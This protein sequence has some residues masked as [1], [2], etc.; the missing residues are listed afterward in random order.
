YSCQCDEGFAGDLCEIML[1]HDFF[2]FGSF[3]VCENTLQGPLCHCERGRTG[4]NCELFKGESAPWSKCGNSTF[5][6]S[7]FQNGKCD[8]VCN[9]AECLFDGNDCQ[10][11]HS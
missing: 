9:N 11:E 4:S 7:S 6:E 8:E 10:P 5:C 3:S 2:C 1:C